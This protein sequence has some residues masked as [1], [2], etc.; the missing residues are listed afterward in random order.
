LRGGGIGANIHNL[1][2]FN[3]D[4]GDNAVNDELDYLIDHQMMNI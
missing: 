4:T 1:S 2:S 3:E